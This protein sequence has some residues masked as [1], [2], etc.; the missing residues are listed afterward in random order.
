MERWLPIPGWE[1]V[2][3][4][5]DLG[6][7]KR[8]THTHNG[9]LMREKIL[10]LTPTG[11]GHLQCGLR[12][13]LHT[14]HSLVMSAFVGPRPDGLVVRHRDDVPSNNRL[15]NLVYGTQKENCEDRDANGYRGSSPER[16]LAIARELSGR[17]KW[18]YAEMAELAGRFG[19]C[20]NT[21]RRTLK[22]LKL[23]T[24]ILPSS[25]V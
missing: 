17:A 20:S 2:Y 13:K 22:A 14:V 19:V 8:V 18:T 10:R 6:R 24:L 16:R 7:V 4:V 12:G 3:E 25:H 5:S 21:V 23:G 9:K 1:G 15:S 11:D